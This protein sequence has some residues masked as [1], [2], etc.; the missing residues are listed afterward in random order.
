MMWPALEWMRIS[1]PFLC[2]AF[3]ALVVQSCPL[4]RTYLQKI[5][6]VWLDREHWKNLHV[7]VLSRDL[8]GDVTDGVFS[9]DDVCQRRIY[10]GFL[11]LWAPQSL[12]E[13]QSPADENWVGNCLVFSGGPPPVWSHWALPVIQTGMKVIMTWVLF[14]NTYSNLSFSTY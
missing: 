7:H 3:I 2:E 6:P 8:Q 10:W 13:L 11:Q 9:Y 12:L 1:H 14:L 4:R 5:H